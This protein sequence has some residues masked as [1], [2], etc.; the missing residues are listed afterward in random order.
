MIRG[1]GIVASR[2]IQR[3]Y[4]ARKRN[5]NIAV[6]HLMQSPKPQGNKFQNTQRLVKNHQFQ[7]FNWPKACSGG[8]LQGNVSKSYLPMK[9]NVYSQ[10]GMKQPLPTATTGSKLP[11]KA[12]AKAGINWLR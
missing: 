1:R 8:E 7:P 11:P 12:S 2:I 5:R 6:L 9:H 10:A 4:E 3:I